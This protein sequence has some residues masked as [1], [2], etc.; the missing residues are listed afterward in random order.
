MPLRRDL[1]A[2][3]IVQAKEEC[4]QAG[5]TPGGSGSGAPSGRTGRLVQLLER[6]G[7]AWAVLAGF[8]VR[9][10]M[11]TALHG[12]ASVPDGRDDATY[13][14]FAR[15]IVETGRLET[16]HFPVGYPVFL[17]P[18]L[19]LGGV[20]FPA[21]RL[22]NVLLSLLT[23]VIVS[24]IAAMLYG[25]RAGLV[26]AW[27]TALYPPLAYMTGRIM[28]ETLFITLLV[29]SLHQFLL[30]DRDPNMRRSLF[31]GALFGMASLVRSNLIAMLAFLPLWLLAR[32]ASSLRSRFVTAVACTG[33]AVAVLMLPGLYFLAQ[34]GEFIPF[35]TNSGQTF[36]GANNPIANGGW[37][38]V[39]DHPELLASIPPEVRR[40]PVA[41][42]K[43]EQKLA[44]QWIRQNPSTFLRLL[45]KKFANAWIPGFQSSETTDRSKVA[46]GLLAV[47]LGLL[48]A[49]AIAGRIVVRPACRDGILL[50]VPAVYTAMSLAFYGNPR[51]GL[52][53]APVLVVYAAGFVA[54]LAGAIARHAAGG[55]AAAQA[56]ALG[57]GESQR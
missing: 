5:G 42:S 13:V 49:G 33:I 8:V 37:I 38:E 29:A 36:Y 51:I 50:S 23:I 56:P 3:Y 32:P 15:M 2:T 12:W 6:H 57:E 22:V 14:R 11:T 7:V 27:M 9:V 39:E 52:F 31:G 40:S 43:A 28:S 53:C 21:V 19:M 45:P 1:R 17:A 18:F 46:A 26:A 4:L 48:L 54:W 55:S 47:S 24:R 16:P 41:Y 34:R 10:A 44:V 25:S 20:A 35:A 30:A